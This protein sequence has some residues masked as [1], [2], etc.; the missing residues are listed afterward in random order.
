MVSI[1]FEFFIIFFDILSKYAIIWLRE[2]WWSMVLSFIFLIVSILANIGLYWGLELYKQ[3]QYVFILIGTIP[4]FYCLAFVFYALLL[5]LYS[6]FLNKKRKIEKPSKFYWQLIRQSCHQLIFFANIKVHVKG[7]ERL[8]KQ[9]FLIVSNHTSMFDPIVILDKIK[10][11][12]LSCVTKPENE[13][14][15]LCGPL[16]HRAGFI[17]IDRN[18][19]FNAI[20]SIQRA[21]NYITK[22]KTSI[23]I[24]PEGTRSRSGELLPFH[25]GSFKIATR[26]EAP[27]VI[28]SIRNANQ[29]KKNFPFKRTHIFLDILEVLTYEKYQDKNTTELAA[30]TQELI[31]KNLER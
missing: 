15:I 25:P 2:S 5:F 3:W 13:N 28:A 31:R 16:I 10:Y 8:P 4:M 7:L 9:P 23:Y 18:N 26:T 1:F 22:Y 29:V 30:L 20:H 24:C 17:P 19:A 11:G 14:I 21:S 6:L 12:P 27:I